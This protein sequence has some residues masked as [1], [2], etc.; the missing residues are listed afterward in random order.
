MQVDPPGRPAVVP[1]PVATNQRS[2]TNEPDGRNVEG[3]DTK[4]VGETSEAENE[5]IKREVR[6]LEQRDREVRAHE[7]AHASAGGPHTGAPQYKLER[8][9]DGQMYAVSGHVD[10]DTSKV[11]G[12]PAATIE[13]MSIVQRAALAPAEP[14]SQDRAV[15]A[16]AARTEAEARV[17]LARERQESGS[18]SEP[19]S[20][21]TAGVVVD[22][23]A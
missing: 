11:S 21:S 8:G 7:Q 2:D 19:K 16:Q 9:P 3:R 23:H 13:K 20:V 17:E 6:D 15:A 10:V 18:G 22:V 4:R 14:S 12:D 5:R 1:P